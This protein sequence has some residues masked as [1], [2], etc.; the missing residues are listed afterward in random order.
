MKVWDV[1]GQ[2]VVRELWSYYLQ[3]SSSAIIFVVDSADLERIVEAK[4]EL[5]ELLEQEAAF[6]SALLVLANKQDL[7]NAKNR[8]QLAEAL[9]ISALSQTRSCA[10]YEVTAISGEGIQEAMTWLADTLMK[11]YK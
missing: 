9:Q 5:H 3:G 2:N 4:N 1:G 6:N 8:I 11:N 7:P 10:V